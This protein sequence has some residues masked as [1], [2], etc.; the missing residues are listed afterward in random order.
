MTNPSDLVVILHTDS[1]EST[2]KARQFEAASLKKGL[3]PL[4]L[5]PGNDL[6]YTE[7]RVADRAVRAVI[8]C[9]DSLSWIAIKLSISHG[10]LPLTDVVPFLSKSSGYDLFERAGFNVLR[11]HPVNSVL[12]ITESPVQGPVFVKPDWSSGV[13]SISPWGYKRFESNMDFAKAVLTQTKVFSETCSNPHAR[14]MMMENVP[15]DGVYCISAVL[16][17]DK[18]ACFGHSFMA[19]SGDDHFYDYVLYDDIG[20]TNVLEPLIAKLWSAGFRSNFL[21]LQCLMRNGVLYP[22]DVNTRLSTYLDTLATTYDPGFHQR[23]LEFI[24]G[25]RDDLTLNLP[26]TSCLIG[27][28]RSDPHRD[29]KELRWKSVDGVWP[30]NFENL[31]KSKASYD[32]AYSWPT[33]LCTGES[34]NEVL[35]KRA[36]FQSL[37]EV[38]Q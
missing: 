35:E 6:R 23:T 1:R 18:V 3:T 2:N 17:E 37:V 38:I 19:I 34:T 11:H 9:S 36:K 26:A 20:H 8:P 28:V 31:S 25:D 29:I 14:L 21:Y 33:Y 7:A 22:M 15:H 32:K 4:L 12:D 16:R 10:L 27:R 5:Q 30:I 24:L 13:H